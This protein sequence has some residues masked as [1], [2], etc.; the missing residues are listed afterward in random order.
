M[1]FFSECHNFLILS[2]AICQN[3]EFSHFDC[4]T[5]ACLFDTRN[6]RTRRLQIYT[7]FR[8]HVFFG[9]TSTAA[10][11]AG[12]SEVGL[13]RLCSIPSPGTETSACLL[14]NRRSMRQTLRMECRLNP[15]RMQI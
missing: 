12:G 6:N 14:P 8:G 2:P 9:T 13:L 15:S 11:G 7:F 5:F 3:R 10:W 4:I 1:K